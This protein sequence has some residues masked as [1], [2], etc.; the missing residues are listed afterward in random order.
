MK[1]TVLGILILVFGCTAMYGQGKFAFG[2]NGGPVVGDLKDAVSVNLAVDFE[3]LHAVTD[4]FEVGGATG[5]IIGFTKDIELPNNQ[6]LEVDN[7]SFIPVA[8]AFRFNVANPLSI[9][10]DTGYGVGINEGNEGGFYY[11]PRLGIGVSESVDLVASYVGVA[12]GGGNYNAATFGVL[13][14][15]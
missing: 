10:V 7:I 12:N 5:Y 4:K 15:F 2:F 11:R 6:N 14:G 9:G 3:Y 13:F 8:I 1:R